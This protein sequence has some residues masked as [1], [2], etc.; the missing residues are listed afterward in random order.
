MSSVWF[1]ITNS[2]W[3]KDF[4]ADSLHERTK[5]FCGC[6]TC[7][8]FGCVLICVVAVCKI[9]GFGACMIAG[10]PHQYEDSCF[11]L[12]MERLRK[13]T[14]QNII[15]SIFT[16]GGFPVTRALKHLPSKCLAAEP[17]IVVLQFATSDLIVPV[18][19]KHRHI[20][21][22]SGERILSSAERKTC[23]RRTRA[24]D[25]LRWR[26]DGLIGDLLRLT[27]LTPPEIYLETMGRMA[28]TISEHQAVPVVLSPFVF[29][30][31]RSDRIARDCA[32]RLQRLLATIPKAHYV[33]AYSALNQHTR[34]QMLL[35]DGCHLTLKGQAVVGE[36]LFASLAKIIQDKNQMPS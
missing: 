9:R 23:P 20:P 33:D 14:R 11:H 26:I 10:F 34:S 30:G 4:R 1:S 17:D 21:H 25:Q 3:R 35:R 32:R 2:S 27:P 7:L 15:S 22:S 13:E 19:E 31:H 18:K 12:A 6:R 5:R 8:V 24:V 29:G 16:L 36:C 28:R